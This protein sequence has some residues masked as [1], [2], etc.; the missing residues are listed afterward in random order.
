MKTKYQ[1]LKQSLQSGLTKGQI[2]SKNFNQCV[3][4]IDFTDWDFSILNFSYAN[5]HSAD[6]RSA[7]FHSADFCSAD[8]RS[9]NFSYADFRFADFR[10]A[11]FRFANFHS[12][13]FSIKVNESTIGL[14]LACPEEGSF[15]GYKKCAGGIIVKLQICEDAK[16]SSATTLKCRASKVLVL[17]IEGANTAVSKYDYR[18]IYRIGQ[19]IEI[20]DFDENRWNECSTGIHFFMN[21]EVAKNYE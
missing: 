5:F 15:I 20:P 6:F 19:I 21:K 17:D 8:F 11:N 16:R 14:L 3:I 12:A 1:M 10:F 9:A 7:N 18:F 13:D 4:Y 2:K